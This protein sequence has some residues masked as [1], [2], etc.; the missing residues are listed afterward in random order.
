[1]DFC[2]GDYYNIGQIRNFLLVMMCGASSDLTRVG[3][4]AGRSG[5]EGK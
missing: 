2:C 4:W 5:K 3:K 1:M